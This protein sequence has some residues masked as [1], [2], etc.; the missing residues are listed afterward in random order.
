LFQSTEPILLT[1]NQHTANSSE[2]NHRVYTFLKNNL[3]GV[4]STVDPEGEPHAAVIYFAVDESFQITFTTRKETKKVNNLKQKNHA[5]LI[6]FDAL[7]Q[8]TVQ[9]TA[10]SQNISDTAEEAQAFR[11]TVRASLTTSD[12]SIPPIAELSAGELIA[13]KLKPVKIKMAMYN[14]SAPGSYNGTYEKIEF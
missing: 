13:F 6:V 7:T 5:M 1:S 2:S 4:L 3:V 11:E 9:I 12:G 14:H 10:T 8:T